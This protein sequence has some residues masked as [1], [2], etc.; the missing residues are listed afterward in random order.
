M[1]RQKCSGIRR[2]YLEVFKEQRQTSSFVHDLIID[3]CCLTGNMFYMFFWNI[4]YFVMQKKPHLDPQIWF[5]C[6]YGKGF[7]SFA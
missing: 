5:L 6:I 7:T 4:K 2:S 3:S 1:V